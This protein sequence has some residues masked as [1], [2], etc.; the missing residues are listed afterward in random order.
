MFNK[1]II[2]I[3]SV[4]IIGIS[5]AGAAKYSY[6]PGYEPPKAQHQTTVV[7]QR[8]PVYRDTGYDYDYDRSAQRSRGTVYNQ[9]A[10]YIQSDDGF[11][12]LKDQPI[13][14]WYV[15]LK[16]LHTFASV[17]A[18]Y[19]TDGNVL[20]IDGEKDS[21]ALS[22]MGGALSLGWNVD[23]NWRLEVEA[24][25]IGKAHDETD[26]YDVSFS[27]PYVNANALYNFSISDDGRHG[28]YVG[29]GLGLAFV[30]SEIENSYFYN[31][32]SDKTTL[33]FMAAGTVGYQYRLSDE[34]LLDVA[35]KLSTF[36]GPEH[37]RQFN[38]GQMHDFTADFGW[39]INHHLSLGVRYEF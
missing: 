7:Y 22:Q 19:K 11:M 12:V 20:G 16:Y 35:Y 27:T 14:K 8:A 6:Q 39:F 38:N 34:W 28:L 37:T 31:G 29:A 18:T 9:Q 36:N 23:R 33:S 1:K 4:S 26:G 32:G 24:G 2:S 13:R 3:L 15:G 30:N 10:G 21:Y 17:K 25:Y 5:A